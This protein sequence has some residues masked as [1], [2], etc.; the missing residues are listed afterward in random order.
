[1]VTI[2]NDSSSK[3]VG[4]VYMQPFSTLL[5]L[6]SGPGIPIPKWVLERLQ[7]GSREV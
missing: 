1:M 4:V 6:T 2:L 3:R 7:K 5:A